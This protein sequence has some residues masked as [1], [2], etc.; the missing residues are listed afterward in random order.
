MSERIV[1]KPFDHNRG[2]GQNFVSLNP[3]K[4]LLVDI[5]VLV[6][7]TQHYDA[8]LSCPIRYR[9]ADNVS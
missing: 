8:C 9:H 2:C 7:V 1:A 4:E 5:Q 6:G 3:R